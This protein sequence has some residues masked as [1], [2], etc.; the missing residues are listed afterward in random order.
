MDPVHGRSFWTG[1]RENGDGERTE[2][3]KGFY[4]T[5]LQFQQN[6]RLA[7][8]CTASEF[9]KRAFAFVQYI[10]PNLPQKFEPHD[11]AE[12]ILKMMPDELYEAGQRVK[13]SCCPDGRALHRPEVP[14]PTVQQ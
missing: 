1:S 9:Q 2:Y 5:A 10:M 11:A 3:D 14:H 4:I 12:Y 6:N 13:L 8:G 7:N